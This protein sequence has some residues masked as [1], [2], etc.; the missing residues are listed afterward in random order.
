MTID[1]I[2]DLSSEQIYRM[3]RKDIESALRVANREGKLI[4]N[5]LVAQ[6][7]KNPDIPK[8]QILRKQGMVDWETYKFSISR[9]DRLPQLRKK[10]NSVVGFL[11][12][13]SIYYDN[14]L[15]TLNKFTNDIVKKATQ[16]RGA[17][18]RFL[19]KPKL[20]GEFYDKFWKVYDKISENE[21]IRTAFSDGS[22]QFQIY[23][24]E[25]MTRYEGES[26]EDIA[27]NILNSFDE[28]YEK[29]QEKMRKSERKPK[30]SSGF[31]RKGI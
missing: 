14:W 5:A 9:G 19:S 27:L 6:T 25:Q 22:P 4:R 24:Y 17:R 8:P 26:V 29:E 16:Q 3:K 20:T 13:K 18:G 10:L 28:R 31:G 11:N 2:K 12:A 30:Y 21:N 1:E 23:L 7:K 15:G